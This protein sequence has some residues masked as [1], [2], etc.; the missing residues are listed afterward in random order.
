VKA[1]LAMLGRI[2]NVLRL[3]LLPMAQQHEG[4][5]RAGLAAAGAL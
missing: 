3:P 2:Q 4:R 1:A 5:L